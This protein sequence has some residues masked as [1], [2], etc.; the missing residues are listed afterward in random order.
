MGDH[1]CIRPFRWDLSKREQL[2][3][4]CPKERAE[5]YE[6]FQSDVRS[7][8][9]KLI[10]RAGHSD[11][12]FVGRS[13][14][15]IFDYLSGIF[16]DVPN[17]PSLILFQLSNRG[18]SA[19]D[20]ARNHPRELAALLAYFT[21]ERLDPRSIANRERQVRFVDVV[22]TGSTFGSLVSCLRYWSHSQPADWNVVKQRIG[23]VGLT[24][25]T[26]SSPN[27]WRWWQHQQWVAELRKSNIKSISVNDLFWRWIANSE[28][29][30]TPSHHVNRWA[31][32]DATKPQRQPRHL[33]ALS[34]AVLLFDLGRDK[35]ERNLFARHLTAQ[36]EMNER[37]LRSIVLGVR[38]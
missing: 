26:K 21:H 12:V 32:E 10:A 29:K 16:Q 34:L 2:G 11:I 37:W 13:T 5:A 7:A 1:V 19:E 27:T 31:S 22:D 8:A 15:A 35:S 38:G 24:I 18:W 25:K 28:E 17:A 36:P 14:E 6:G 20:L 9:A 4:L 3:A 23:F 33:K 30:V